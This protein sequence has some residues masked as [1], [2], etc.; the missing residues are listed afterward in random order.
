MQWTEKQAT[1]LES[2]A[3]KK[4]S[5]FTNTLGRGWLIEEIN[6]LIL[7]HLQIEF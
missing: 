2:D 4:N 1:N 6:E 7:S 3:K 5:C